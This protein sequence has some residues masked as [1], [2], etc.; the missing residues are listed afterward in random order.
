MLKTN[1]VY[2]DQKFIER[3]EVADQKRVKRM[4]NELANMGFTVTAPAWSI[5]VARF[6]PIRPEIGERD[7]LMPL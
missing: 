1:R 4:L 7:Y 2:D 6:D 5:F 3:K